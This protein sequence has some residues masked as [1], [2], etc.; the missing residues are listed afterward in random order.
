[1]NTDHFLARKYFDGWCVLS[2]KHKTCNQCKHLTYL[3]QDVNRSVS[4][5]GSQIHDSAPQA[6]RRHIFFS[7]GAVLSQQVPCSSVHKWVCILRWKTG[8]LLVDRSIHP[9]YG[10]FAPVRI[11]TLQFSYLCRPIKIE[12]WG[13][14]GQS[15]VCHNSIE[16]TR[17][18]CTR[19]CIH[20]SV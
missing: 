5:W 9:E 6:Y 1:M 15:K 20:S 14:V 2:V 8:K 16:T 10:W 12:R 18:I 11:I 3:S 4:I 19:C 13:W 17:R 7:A